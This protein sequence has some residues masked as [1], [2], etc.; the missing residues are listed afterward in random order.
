MKD[1]RYI[2]ELLEKGQRA[3]GRKLD[4]F[5]KVEIETNPYEKPE[6]CA[7]VSI[8]KTK[9]MAG[10]KMDVGE[11]FSDRPDEGVLMVNAELSPLA[12]PDFETGPPRVESIELARVVDRGI[13]ESQ[14]LDLKKLCI[15]PGEKVWMV[16]I[17]LQIINHDGNLINAAGLAAISALMN[18]R[19]P[20]YKDD[21]V[22]YT[23][24]SKKLPTKTEPV[25]VIVSKVGE[26]LLVDA[27]VTEE[28]LIKTALVVTT[29]D[30]GNICALQKLGTEGLGEDDVLKM[31]G[32]A[33][34]KCEELRKL[35]K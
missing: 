4:E 32:M 31:W 27:D 8:G 18:T 26:H 15:T 22:N 14:V 20:E 17:D 2:K 10:V 19:M 23:K 5:R 21:K 30:D 1:M 7:I 29:D 11:P 3:D 9:V 25:P 12:S 34:K 6:G 16:F 28:E 35:L 24:K 13:R 33:V